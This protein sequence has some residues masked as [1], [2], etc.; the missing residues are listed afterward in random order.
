LYVHAVVLQRWIFLTRPIGKYLMCPNLDVQAGP[1][2]RD[3][4]SA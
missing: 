4:T 2:N 3:L 1:G